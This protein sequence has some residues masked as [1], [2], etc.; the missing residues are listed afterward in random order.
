MQRVFRDG[1]TNEPAVAI[2][3][4]DADTE[5]AEINSCNNRHQITFLWSK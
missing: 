1:R 3:E 4:R 2:D 5:C